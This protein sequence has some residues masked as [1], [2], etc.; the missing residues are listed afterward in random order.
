VPVGIFQ[1]THEGH[2]IDMNEELTRILGYTSKGE[3]LRG[4]DEILSDLLVR[5]EGRTF[6]KREKEGCE[7]VSTFEIDLKRHDGRVIHVRLCVRPCPSTTEENGG[8]IG[9]IEDIS[10]Q[11]QLNKAIELN[12]L[13]YRSVF[14][15]TDDAILIIRNDKLVD[16]NAKAFEYFA[17]SGFALD[18]IRLADI[19]PDNQPSG[20]VSA[21]KA[22]ELAGL[23]LQGIPQRVEWKHKRLNGTLF[24]AEVTLS[25]LGDEQDNTYQIIVRDISARKESDKKVQQAKANYEALFEQAADGIVVIDLKGKIIDA[26]ES[27]LSITG[28]NKDEV[29]GRSINGFFTAA[30]LK[31]NPFRIDLL[32]EQKAVVNER[33]LLKKDGTCIEVQFNTRLLPDQRIQTIIRDITERRMSQQAIQRSEEMYRNIV[34]LSP[35]GIVT[36]TTSGTILSVNQAFIEMSGYARED[37]E[38]K[39]F[40]KIPTMIPQ[41]ASTYKSLYNAIASGTKRTAIEFIWKHRD[42]QVRYGEAK[43]TL[44]KDDKYQRVVQGIFRDTTERYIAQQQLKESEERYRELF[45]NSL[46]GRIRSDVDGNSMLINKKMAEIFGFKSK[47]ALEYA[48]K[49]KGF[50]QFAPDINMKELTRTLFEKGIIDGKLKIQAKNGE[51]K[52]VRVMA[53]AIDDL[54]QKN[55]YIDCIFDDITHEEQLNLALKKSESLLLSVINAFPFDLFVINT[56]GNILMQNAVSKEYWGVITTY[57][58]AGL[59]NALEMAVKGA[60]A[61]ESVDTEITARLI[62]GMPIDLRTIINPLRIDAEEHGGAIILNIDI[63]EQQRLKRELEYHLLNLENNVKERTT[64]IMKLNKALIHSNEELYGLNKQLQSQKISLEELVEELKSTQEQ[65]VQSKKLASIGILTAGVAHEINNPINFINSGAIG[66]ELGIERLIDAI[67]AYKICCAKLN[68]AAAIDHFETIS[69]QYNVETTI[70]NIPLLLKSIKN[71]INRTVAIVKGLRT[72]SHMEN[73][74][75]VRSNVN[76]LIELALTI[77]Y[78]KYK[79]R[80]IIEKEYCS[81]AAIDCYPGK[82][83]Q[84]FLNLLTNSIQAIDDNG[85]ITITTQIDSLTGQIMVRISDTGKGIPAEVQQ[86]VFDPFFTTK[87]VGQGTGLGLSIVHGIVKEHMGSITMESEQG[88]GTTFTLFLPQ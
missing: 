15:H 43:V 83:G 39:N 47:K 24:D 8:Y 4:V 72:F 11:K 28:F 10:L 51:E 70:E 79:N 53:K 3:A 1:S 88:Y 38:G 59:G 68:D 42:G 21:S 65:L 87:P 67:K 82:L 31:T 41:N 32:K 2:T 49:E 85:F 50:E 12:H 45:D 27:I 36:M 18:S 81:D 75:K 26:N 71:G 20:E 77:L 40:L 69:C 25:R 22:R 63:T 60:L 56:Q 48:L 84:L 52:T 44:V 5:T 86:K 46:V 57:R 29:V 30:E 19:H 35:D 80:I 76:E 23:A 54:R 58:D 62:S 16:C 6:I 9:V 74:T 64:E 66:L 73:E 14:D 34:E 78:D 17:M 61:G 33:K 7:S 37:F 13:V 55:S